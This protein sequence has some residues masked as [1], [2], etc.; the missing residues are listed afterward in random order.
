MNARM[1]GETFHLP[2]RIYY[3]DTDAGG[4]VYY[5]NYLKY[6]ERARTE[7]LRYLG[8]EQVED[9]DSAERYGFI[10]RAAELEYLKPS[11]LDDL[12][13]V[14]CKIDEVK[15]ASI[16]CKQEIVCNG[17]VR[18]KAKVTAV[19]ISLSKMRPMRVPEEMIKVFKDG[20]K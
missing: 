14:T 15:G 20:K 8:F 9:L 5:A 1:I 18:V 19:Y 3:E 2:V 12:I 13:E 17:E 7:F 16:V 11:K 10:V 4:I 6:A